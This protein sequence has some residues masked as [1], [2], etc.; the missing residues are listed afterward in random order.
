MK[1]TAS[2]WVVPPGR[3]SNVLTLR[4]E[5]KPGAAEGL[6]TKAA[7]RLAGVRSVAFTPNG[8]VVAAVNGGGGVVEKVSPLVAEIDALPTAPGPSLKT[9]KNQWLWMLMGESAMESLLV[10]ASNGTAWWSPRTIC[11]STTA[12]QAVPLHDA[13][14]AAGVKRAIADTTTSKSPKAVAVR[15]IPSL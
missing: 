3:I 11:K 14:A 9:V 12:E 15:R 1:L 8:A 13:D 10:V 4:D 6:A 2:V 7:S 5:V